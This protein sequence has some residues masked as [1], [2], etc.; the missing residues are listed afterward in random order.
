MMTRTD[1]VEFAQDLAGEGVAIPSPLADRLIA[2][3]LVELA[4]LGFGL[5]EK[6]ASITFAKDAW[7]ELPEDFVIEAE[8]VDAGTGLPYGRQYHVRNGRMMLIES[9]NAN[10]HYLRTAG[11]FRHAKQDTANALTVT[12]PA[13][14][15]TTLV[16]RVN[17]LKARYQAHIASSSHHKNPDAVN[18]ISSPDA[19]GTSSAITLANEIRTDLPAHAV[20]ADVHFRDDTRLKIACGV[21]TDLATCCALVEEMCSAFTEHL[22]SGLPHEVFTMALATYVAAAYRAHLKGDDVWATSL[23]ARFVQAAQRASATLARQH[24]F[25]GLQQNRTVR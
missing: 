24:R 23:Y 13:T 10:V 9:L 16:A 1:V 3:G 12:M 5:E 8:I 17:N 19:T 25:G 18:T 21:A 2:E 15:E 22:K 14:T 20:K 7:A 4:H 6:T 11:P